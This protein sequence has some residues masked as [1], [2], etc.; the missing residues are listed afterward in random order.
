MR[1]LL[2]IGALLAATVSAAQAQE[3]RTSEEFSTATVVEIVSEKHEEEFGAHRLVQSVRLRI[4]DGP[5]K[6]REFEMENGVL[7]GRA[8]M[9]LAQGD[10]VVVNRQTRIDGSVHYLLREAY[11]LPSLLWIAVLFAVLSLVF[12]GKTGVSAIAGLA[13]SI[14][15]LVWFVIPRIVSGADPLFAAFTGCILIACTS[16][17][18]AHGFHRRT[19]VAL[20]S[21]VVT[22][23]LAVIVDVLFVRFA[24]LFGMGSEESVFL[25][26]GQFESVDLRGLLLAGILIGCLGVLDDITTAQTAAVDEISKANPSL[27]AS[28]LRAAGRSVGREHIASLINTLALAYAGASLPLLLLLHAETDYPLWVTLNGEFFAEEIIRTLVGSVTLLFAV[29]ISTGF[30]AYFLQGGR[31]GGR[32]SMHGHAH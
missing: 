30:A 26:T 21:T 24:S 27:S 29:P 18:L 15:I 5:E 6:G 13:V 3:S 28:R 17:Y 4:D 10:R 1:R 2:F 20:L 12:G 22:L 9:R 16:L 31:G 14:G 8:D 7:D 23:I 11:R 25:Q 19:S 32:R